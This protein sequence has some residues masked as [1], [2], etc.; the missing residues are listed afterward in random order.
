MVLGGD[1]LGRTLGGNNN[2]Y[3]HDA[4]W[5]WLPWDTAPAD[6]RSPLAFLRGLVRLRR[7]GVSL[8]GED[9]VEVAAESAAGDA[10]RATWI[11][12]G[13]GST[14]C[15]GLLLVRGGSEDGVPRRLLLLWNT[16][17]E[18]ASVPLPEAEDG[19]WR[20]AVDTH[21]EDGGLGWVPGEV[22]GVPDALAALPPMPPEDASVPAH[23]LRLL[24]DVP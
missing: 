3:C 18:A 7:A 12:S 23:A 10:D 21:A 17:G 20:L 2:A 8:D 11:G 9:W 15:A 1:E 24:V 19:S 14:A 22:S 13:P 16:T 4:E 6:G 5:N